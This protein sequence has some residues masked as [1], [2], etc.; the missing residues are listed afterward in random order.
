MDATARFERIAKQN[1]ENIKRLL[2]VEN[3]SLKD[4][5]YNNNNQFQDDSDGEGDGGDQED[6]SY[7]KQVLEKTKNTFKG[8]TSDDLGRTYQY[9]IDSLSSGANIC[10]ICI[11]SIKKTDPIWNCSGCYGAFHIV[12]IQKWIK[13]GV[14][15]TLLHSDNDSHNNKKQQSVAWHCPKCRAEFDQKD[16]PKRYYCYCLKEIDPTFDPWSVPHSCGQT[17]GKDLIPN[18]GHICLL[19]CHPGPC[20]PCAKQV[21][22][23]CYCSQSGPT[24]RRCGYKGWSC[25]LKCSKLLSCQHHKCEQICHPGSCSPCN[26]TSLKTCLCGRTKDV[27]NCNEA[28]FQCDKPCNRPLSC[29]IHKCEKICHTGACGKCPREGLRTCP[30]GKTKYENL[31]CSEDIMPCGDTCGKRLDCGKHFCMRRCHLGDCETC[32]QMTTKKCRCGLKEKS[33]PCCQEYLCE[34]KCTKM[35]ICGKHQCKK[36]S[37]RS[38]PNVPWTLKEKS[39]LIKQSL[40]C[41]PC[42]VQTSVSCFGAHDTKL[43]PCSMAQQYCCGKIC[44]RTLKCGNHICNLPCHDV[45]DAPN[46]VE[47]GKRCIHCEEMCSKQRPNG[48][49]HSCPLMCHPNDCPRCLQRLRFR[50]HCNSEVLYSNCHTFTSSSPEEQEKIKSC[51]KPCSKILTC[52]HACTWKCHSGPCSPLS[53]CTKSVSIRC[54]CKHL[55]HQVPCNE[56]NTNKSGHRL[57]CDDTCIAAKNKN[58]NRT[59][60]FTSNPSESNENDDTESTTISGETGTEQPSLSPVIAVPTTTSRKNRK[61]ANAAENKLSSPSPLPKSVLTKPVEPSPNIVVPKK[62]K[63]KPSDKMSQSTAIDQTIA[64]DYMKE[65][66]DYQ[67]NGVDYSH[68]LTQIRTYD[69]S[70]QDCYRRVK[71]LFHHLQVE[72]DTSLQ[73]HNPQQCQTMLIDALIQAKI[74]GDNKMRLSQQILDSTEKKAKKLKT[75]FQKYSTLFFD[76]LFVHL[77]SYIFR[78]L[79]ESIDQQYHQHNGSSSDNNLECDSENEYD[80]ESGPRSTSN[81]P[82]HDLKRDSIATSLWKRKT[83]SSSTALN[84]KRK[85]NDQNDKSNTND[86]DSHQNSRDRKKS[87]QRHTSNAQSTSSSGNGGGGGGGGSGGTGGAGAGGTN[88]NKKPKLNEAAVLMHSEEPTY[89]LCSQLSYGEMICCDNRTCEI[90]WFHFNCVNLTTKPKGKWYC[91]RCR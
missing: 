19:L 9:L 76:E 5:E 43:V 80:S 3:E 13:D 53:E 24:A 59:P 4:D 60:S 36:K 78:I 50:C 83:T 42:Q 82:K 66:M 34:T 46:S 89:C 75:A 16:T 45:K 26:K 21:N 73:L 33:V 65:Y 27:R 2:S 47:A 18:C 57:P 87:S 90:E 63:S 11:D 40:P 64:F 44:G 55:V 56:V 86:H 23:R 14:Y 29:S 8:V 67:D 25:S 28:V 32:R 62:V 31:P 48:C 69:V 70:L 52:G 22:V 51:Q 15:Q 37:Q 17:C 10:L 81:Y 91:P 49:S 7:I 20:P 41:P 68:S 88:G 74:I 84:L 72:N 6:D 54:L 1:H 79:V 71:E 35:R 77:K 39:K 58:K 61:R 38:T 12:C 85:C 30:C